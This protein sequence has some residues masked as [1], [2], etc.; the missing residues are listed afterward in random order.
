MMRLS[1]RSNEASGKV[2]MALGYTA[3]EVLFFSAKC[4]LSRILEMREIM[5]S[6]LFNGLNL[7]RLIG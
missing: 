6:I 1:A 4:E 2:H 7:N 3:V 5:L